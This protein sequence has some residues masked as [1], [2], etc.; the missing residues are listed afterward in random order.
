MAPLVWV[1]PAVSL[2]ALQLLAAL[3]LLRTFYVLL[4]WRPVLLLPLGFALFTPLTVPSF[5]WWAAGLNYLPM[6]AALA[7]VCGDAVLLVRTGDRRYAVTAMAAYFAGL[8]FFEKSAV[9]PFVAFTI[10][11]LLCWV[12]GQP[13]ALG[14]VWRRGRS[15]CWKPPAWSMRS[16]APHV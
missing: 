14:W 11:V 7:W 8:L 1:W 12:S 13:G 5:A 6:L 15:L 10:A 9:I 16:A 3:A 4:G 2:L